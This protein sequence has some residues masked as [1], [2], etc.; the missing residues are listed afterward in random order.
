VEGLKLEKLPLID[1]SE[2]WIVNELDRPNETNQTK[3]ADGVE[4]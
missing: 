3:S 2:S 1:V 4:K